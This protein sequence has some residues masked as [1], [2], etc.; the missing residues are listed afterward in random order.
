MISISKVSVIHRPDYFFVIGV[1]QISVEAVFSRILYMNTNINVQ[2]FELSIPI[3]VN[4]LI[5]IVFLLN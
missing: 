5:G 3:D 4:T 2:I 1:V